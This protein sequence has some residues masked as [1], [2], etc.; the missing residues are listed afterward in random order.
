M[1]KKQFCHTNTVKF[2]KISFW[3]ETQNSMIFPV[4]G[5]LKLS[6]RAHNATSFIPNK[7]LS[8]PDCSV[9]YFKSPSKGKFIEEKFCSG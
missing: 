4:F 1:P 5:C 7:L 3:G 2:C 8:F 9:P 6:L